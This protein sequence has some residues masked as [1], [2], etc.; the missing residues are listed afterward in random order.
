MDVVF[1]H[2]YFQYE[3]GRAVPSCNYNMLKSVLLGMERYDL[4]RVIERNI[5]G[6]ENDAESDEDNT[7]F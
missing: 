2:W 3:R 1:S 7:H 6:D 5:S 4:I